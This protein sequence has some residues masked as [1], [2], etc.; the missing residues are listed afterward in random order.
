M[1][2]FFRHDKVLEDMYNDLC[3]VSN[4]TEPRITAIGEN[5]QSQLKEDNIVI[6]SLFKY[7][8]TLIKNLIELISTFIVTIQVIYIPF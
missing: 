6:E 1:I 3:M 2:L 5:L 4:R 8:G 7:V